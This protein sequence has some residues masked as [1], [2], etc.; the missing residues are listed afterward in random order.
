[1][2]A[3]HCRILQNLV[4]QYLPDSGIKIN[5]AMIRSNGGHTTVNIHGYV[6]ES[7][8]LELTYSYMGL[9]MHYLSRTTT[10]LGDTDDFVDYNITLNGKIICDEEYQ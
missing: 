5:S 2:S 8:R 10:H 1:M 3:Q 9:E 7:E 4:D 6:F